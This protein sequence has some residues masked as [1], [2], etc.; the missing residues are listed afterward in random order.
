MNQH[1][2][3]LKY[4]EKQNSLVKCKKKVV[5]QKTLFT[6]VTKKHR[7]L[8]FTEKCAILTFPDF[9]QISEF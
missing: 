7:L 4:F 2:K 9:S 1:K 8:Y 6:N 5:S 3:T